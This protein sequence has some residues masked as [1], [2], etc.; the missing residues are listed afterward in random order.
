MLLCKRMSIRPTLVGYRDKRC[1]ICVG[2]VAGSS[3]GVVV[4]SSCLRYDGGNAVF[5]DG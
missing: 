4:K 2:N 3:G 1:G 5:G